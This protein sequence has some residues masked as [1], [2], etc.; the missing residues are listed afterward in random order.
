MTTWDAPVEGI[1]QFKG[2]PPGLDVDVVI[3]NIQNEMQVALSIL[4]GGRRKLEADAPERKLRHRKRTP[5]SKAGK[6]QA[7]DGGTE[8]EI[9]NAEESESYQSFVIS[10]L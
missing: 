9:P 1:V 10:Q 5:K 8:V 4:L 3:A 6:S 7:D 2:F